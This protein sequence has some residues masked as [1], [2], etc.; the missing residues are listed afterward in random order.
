[1]RR[2]I[3]IALVGFALALTADAQNRIASGST[4]RTI[5]PQCKLPY[6]VWTNAQLWL[7]CRHDPS[8]LSTW[9]VESFGHEASKNNGTSTN[10]SVRPAFVSS[11]LDFDGVDDSITMGDVLDPLT[12]DF[13]ISLWFKLEAAA[14]T[15][16][17]FTKANGSYPDMAV[18]LIAGPCVNVQVDVDA[19]NFRNVS[20]SNAVPTNA[21]VHFVTTVARSG[22]SILMY[23]N[24]T[25]VGVA[26]GG[27][28][29]S[30]A[31]SI[32]TAANLIIG[33]RDIPASPYAFPGKIDNV[34]YINRVL[35][36]AEVL[37]IY[38][39][40]KAPIPARP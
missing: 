8:R 17:L 20:T 28:A 27:S 34:L 40:Q 22:G 25:Q 36:A 35:T 7:T 12:S 1:M 16:S 31:G 26:I 6:G 5:E 21:W 32:D 13:S 2:L 15:G 33:R 9:T 3:A 10:V 23:T 19:S 30:I 29:G 14:G 39:R 38:N 11:C 4:Y 24:G 37:D 18:Y